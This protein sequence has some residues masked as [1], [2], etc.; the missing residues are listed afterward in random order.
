[1]TTYRK[2]AIATRVSPAVNKA[3]RQLTNAL[4]LTISEYLRKLILDDLESKGM[5]N[6]QIKESIEQTET[7][8][9]EESPRDL[10]KRLWDQS[11][12]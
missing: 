4:G 2:P 6:A 8:D 3:V 7:M 10:I 11:E 9:R 5:F 12:E 1:M